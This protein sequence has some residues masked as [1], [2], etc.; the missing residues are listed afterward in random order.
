MNSERVETYWRKRDDEE[1]CYGNEES[2]G[3]TAKICQYNLRSRADAKLWARYRRVAT[4]SEDKAQKQHPSCCSNQMND[5]N[6]CGAHSK[7]RTQ[8]CGYVRCMP[9]HSVI[10]PAYTVHARKQAYSLVHPIR[11]RP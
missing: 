6:C 3:K 9:S 8:D 7:H 11:C 1:D 5:V 4:I 10:V 2:S